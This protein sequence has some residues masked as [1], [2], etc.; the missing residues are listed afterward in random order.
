MSNDTQLRGICDFLSK[1]QVL[2]LSVAA[3]G[4]IW[5][6]SCFYHFNE[7]KMEMYLMSDT[8]TR[9]AKLM[10]RE[11]MISGTITSNVK[12]ITQMSGI[13]YR[14]NASLL[15]GDRQKTARKLYCQRFPLSRVMGLPM[16]QLQLTEVK[17]TQRRLGVKQGMY[18]ER[19]Y[20]KEELCL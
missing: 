16:W 9:H 13:Q 14:A 8:K 15:S 18:W 6:A 3:E 2:S 20:A 19:P 12:S 1:E 11:P 4:Q 17:L 5:S 7:E 10:A